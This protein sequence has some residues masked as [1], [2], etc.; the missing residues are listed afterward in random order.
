MPYISPTLSELLTRTRTDI[1]TRT[2]T[3]N[4]ATEGVAASAAA[5]AYGLYGRLSWIARN[6]V[7]HLADD[8][9]LLRHCEF[10]GVWRKQPTAAS[11]IIQVD[12]VG[13]AV[14]DIGTRWQ[15]QDGVIFTSTSA[16]MVSDAGNVQVPVE[17][18]EVGTSGNT[19]ANIKVELLSPVVNVKSA[20]I[21]AS[22]TISGG[23]AIES[24]D[25]LRSRLL[26]RVQYPPSG[27]NTHDYIRWALECAGVTRAWCFS[28]FGR[29]VI[30]VLFVLDGQSDIFPTGA[31]IERVNDY[32]T[33][34]INPLTNQWEGKPPCV[35]L[36]V[37][38]PKKLPLNPVIR[39]SPKT[40]AT[41]AAVTAAL[42]DLLIDAEPGGMAYQSKM[43]AAVATADG[44]TDGKIVSLSGDVYA[45]EHE[46]IVLGDITW[47]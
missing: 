18:V 9:I 47:Q 29:N 14:I 22:T 28:T 6:I 41:Q 12:T 23:A 31:D 19:A 11:G 25:S 34:H 38:G 27:G 46:L 36:I 5:N 1:E 20:A 42:T 39:L 33:A 30:T 3:S 13:E 26:L 24:V 44:V 4:L 35:E 2:G 43:D 16:V 21:V 37:S 32:I 17:A 7:P 15:R 10:W 8:D 45:R 40:P